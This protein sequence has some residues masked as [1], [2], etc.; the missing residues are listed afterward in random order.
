M[1]PDNLYDDVITRYL[2]NEANPE[3]VT[4]IEEWMTANDEN[5]LY[6]ESLRN[7][8]QLVHLKQEASKIDVDQEWDQFRLEEWRDQSPLVNL[9]VDKSS[10]GEVL[11]NEKRHRRARIYKVLIATSIAASVIFIIGW[12]AGWF[13]MP[14]QHGAVVAQQEKLGE[15][16]VKVDP[17]MAV[18]QHEVNVSG[19]TKQLI[20]PDGSEI[21]L[22]DSSELTYKEPS[23]GSRRDV[24]L[25]G[26]ADFK[27]AKNKAKPFSVF[28]E[29][30]STT[31]IGTKF[32]VTAKAN[33]PFIHVRLHEGKVVVKP[34]KVDDGKWT[35]EIYLLPGQELIYDKKQ[36]KVT[37]ISFVAEHPAVNQFASQT[38]DSPSIPHHNKGS[39]FMFNNQPLSEIFDALSEMYDARIVYAKKDVKNKYFIGT[40]DKSDS[41]EKILK[42]IALLNNLRVTK[43]NDT[44]RIEQQKIKN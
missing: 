24:Y 44:F 21:A 26:K 1:G 33:D 30:I 14:A 12:A 38:K 35:K 25:V 29:G 9:F 10:D 41:L 27:V 34:L 37:V 13:S 2:L 8:L 16:Q 43:Q 17:L 28:S 22:S 4:F 32:T 3:E 15:D 39:W 36:K 20:L 23:N 31:A 19:K 7:L 6:V 11:N 42:Q 40:Y 5:R 18:V